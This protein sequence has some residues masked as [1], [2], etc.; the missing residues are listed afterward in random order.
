M[1]TAY[2][3][4]LGDYLKPPV[5]HRIERGEGC[6]RVEASDNILV[7]K[8]QITMLGQDGGVLEKGEA[9]RSE[10]NWWEFTSHIEGITVI[11]EAWD[12]P[13]NVTKSTL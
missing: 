13:G 3:L 5:I 1:N 10:G 4:A 8:V 12:L 9:L 6:I 2:S 11:A 7:T